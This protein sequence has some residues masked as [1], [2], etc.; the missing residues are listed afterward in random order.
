MK[1]RKIYILNGSSR[2]IHF[3]LNMQEMNFPTTTFQTAKLKGWF[4]LCLFFFVCNV[5][6][7]QNIQLKINTT[8][9]DSL[10]FQRIVPTYQSV[11]RDTLALKKELSQVMQALQM[12]GFA[13]VS[14]DSL[15]KKNAFYT[16]FLQIGKKYTWLSLEKGNVPNAYLAKMQ[17]Q[18]RAF[19][20]RIFYVE[21]VEKLAMALLQVAA[22]DGFP[23]ASVYLAQIKIENQQIKASLHLEK[24]RLVTFGE[25]K[26]VG[27][28]R[29][30]TAFL[31][32][33]L[34]IK[35]GMPFNQ[36][37]LQNSFKLLR[38]LHFLEVVQPPT[39]IFSANKAIVRIEAT[40]KQQNQVEALMGVQTNERGNAQITGTGIAD[41]TNILARGEQFSVHFQRPQGATQELKLSG[42]YPYLAGSPFGVQG[43]MRQYRR[44][45]TYSEVALEGGVKYF[46]RG[47][48]CVHFFWNTYFSNLNS[49][50]VAQII[51]EKKL[52]TILDLRQ[53]TFGIAYQVQ[54]V[55]NTLH[56]KKGYVFHLKAS[57]GT[58]KVQPNNLITNLKDPFLPNFSF[59][60]LYD[61]LQKEVSMYHFLGKAMCFLPIGVH[62]TLK[63]ALQSGGQFF[64]K[65][66]AFQNEKFRI[67]GNQLMRGFNE[68][69]IFTDFY[70]V[71]TAEYRILTGKNAFLYGFLDEGWVKNGKTQRFLTGIGIGTT[72]ETKAGLFGVS[73]ALGK[74]GRNAL[75][76]RDGKV[77]IG[78]FGTL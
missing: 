12:K 77:H 52:P 46:L 14:L 61:T 17:F 58:R 69:S 27:N 25:V 29:I 48:D 70:A 59:Q 34:G 75:N 74:D 6:F 71:G 68:Q 57:A 64:S 76:F 55:D 51:S 15:Q 7:A 13:A 9:I 18:E 32:N 65:T 63:I 60:T 10:D 39:V 36:S 24:G 47:S 62:N 66:A 20:Q 4:Q 26:L 56:P 73:Y 37:I 35:K 23:F 5:S 50:Q 2:E 3:S 67:G 54:N 42:Q 49:I 30:S 16:A 38:D 40:E 72:L 43:N 8:D 53:N 19:Q 1:N 28:A 41:F 33:Y 11:F 78:Y 22:S 45:S 31:A 44:D 21:E